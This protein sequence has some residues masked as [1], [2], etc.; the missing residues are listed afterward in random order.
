MILDLHCHT[1]YSFDCRSPL[2]AVLRAARRRG[3]DALAITDHDTIEGALEAQR[4][5]GGHPLIIIGQEITTDAGDIIGLFLLEPVT[6]R[7]ALEVIAHIR[8]QGGVAVLP[9]PFQKTPSVPE[10]VARRLHACEGFN[11]RYA[12][13]AR[14]RDGRGDERSMHLAQEYGLTVVASSDAHTPRDV[15]RGRTIVSAATLE[16]ARRALLAGRTA[17]EG[18]RPSLPE[19]WLRRAGAGLAE[20]LDPLPE[21]HLWPSPSEPTRANS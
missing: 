16:E 15:G 13:I 11:A 2:P 9:H 20:L 12:T 21:A 5:A 17:I 6:S 4:R 10:E 3:L 8:E 19:Y 1:Q 14:V 7:D 18:E